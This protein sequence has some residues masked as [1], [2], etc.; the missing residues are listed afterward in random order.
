LWPYTPSSRDTNI[1]GGVDAEDGDIVELDFNDTSL[2][3]DPEAFSKALKRTGP[4]SQPQRNGTSNG[5]EQ[6]VS[7]P[8]KEKRNRR[9]SKRDAAKEREEIEKSWDVPDYTTSY[10]AQ[11]RAEAEARRPLLE[12]PPA[13]PS[14]P[15]SPS[16]STSAS[17]YPQTPPPAQSAYQQQQQG[18]MDAQTP[19]MGGRQ[20]NSTSA[21]KVNG[22]N[23]LGVPTTPSSKGKK[24]ALVNGVSGAATATTT[25]NGKIDRELVKSGLVHAMQPRGFGRLDRNDFVREV[26][27]LIHVCLFLIPVSR[28]RWLTG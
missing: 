25:T 4:Q 15:P 28:F 1:N 12:S 19:T 27:T 24:A 3:S 2:L 9:R 11:Q 5:F 14:P 21:V 13:T 20:L 17:G 26:L 10:V 23:V 18:G 6:H 22:R 16:T 7:P 8:R